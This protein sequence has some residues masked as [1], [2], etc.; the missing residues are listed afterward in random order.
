MHD[1]QAEDLRRSHIKRIVVIGPSGAGKSMLSRQL[2]EILDLP[3][4]H[5]DAEHWRPGW[6]EPPM[7][8]W[9]QRTRELAQRGRWIID[10]NF[11]NTMSERL[12]YADAVIFLDF[13]RWRCLWQV[14]KRV[15]THRGRTRPDMGPDCPER[16]DWE[17][18]EYVFN[19]NDDHRPNVLRRLAALD[20]RSKHVVV[21]RNRR[22][23]EAFVAELQASRTESLAPGVDDRKKRVM[24]SVFSS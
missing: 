22:E 13:S 19:Y 4:I 21:L 11:G 1:H 23:V 6:E 18:I 24:N 7:P 17:F 20:T 16:W 5:L 3:V 2:G 10:G 9:I 15:I 8:W 14:I 12:S